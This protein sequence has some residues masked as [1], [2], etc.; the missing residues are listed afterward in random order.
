MHRNRKTD[1]TTG[2]LR[3]SLLK[4]RSN[5]ETAEEAASTVA[6]GYTGAF[7]PEHGIDANDVAELLPKLAAIRDAMMND[8]LSMLAGAK[9][10]PAAYEPLDAAFVTMPERLLREYEAIVRIVSWR[11]CFEQPIEYK[12]R[13]IVSSFSEL[14]VRTWGPEHWFDTCCQPYWNE[15]SRAQRGSRPRIYFEATMLITMRLKDCCI[16]SEQ[17]RN[18][19]HRT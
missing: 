2:Y 4:R 10:I 13:L 15:L 16:C 18:A 14:V 3:E 1:H 17:I 7:H 12:R 8:E 9:P 19:L 11:D 6:S 5:H